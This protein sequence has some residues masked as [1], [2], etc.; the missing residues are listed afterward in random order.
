MKDVFSKKYIKSLPANVFVTKYREDH[1]YLLYKL[2]WKKRGSN[3]S[4]SWVE[5]HRA[6]SILKPEKCSTMLELNQMPN[7]YLEIIPS[8][9][10]GGTTYTIKYGLFFNPYEPDDLKIINKL[11]SKEAFYFFYDKNGEPVGFDKGGMQ[12]SDREFL[13]LD[14]Y[15]EELRDIRLP[16][17]S[18]RRFNSEVVIYY[19]KDWETVPKKY[20]ISPEF[21]IEYVFTQDDL[22]LAADQIWYYLPTRIDYDWDKD[23]TRAAA[24]YFIRSIVH[25]DFSTQGRI[26]IKYQA[27]IL[28]TILDYLGHKLYGKLQKDFYEAVLELITALDSDIELFKTYFS[29]IRIFILRELYEIQKTG[30]KDLSEMSGYVY[31]LIRSTWITVYSI[32][33]TKIQPGHYFYVDDDGYIYSHKFPG[34]LSSSFQKTIYLLESLSDQLL[35]IMGINKCNDLIESSDNYSFS[36][37]YDD[38]PLIENAE[39]ISQDMLKSAMKFREYFITEP[40]EVIIEN[41]IFKSITFYDCDSIYCI[42]KIRTS[43]NKVSY[44]LINKIGFG[45]DWSWWEQF[46]KGQHTIAALCCAIYRDFSVSET[47]LYEKRDIKILK[48]TSKKDKDNKPLNKIVYLP[49][50]KTK[51]IDDTPIIRDV[52][53]KLDRVIERRRHDVSAHLRKVRISASEVQLN[54]ALEYGI[55]V[56]PGYTFVRP[57]HRSGTRKETIYKSRS[58]FGLLIEASR[59]SLSEVQNIIR[60]A[61]EAHDDDMRTAREDLKNWKNILNNFEEFEL[62]VR[63]LVNKMGVE[64]QTTKRS[65]DGGIDIIAEDDRGLARLKYIFQCKFYAPENTVAVGEVR[66]ILGVKAADPTIDKAIFVTSST[67]SPEAHKFAKQNSIT[68]IDGEDLF[69]MVSGIE[70]K[71][72]R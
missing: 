39:E 4:I 67:F 43:D 20:R 50:F 35:W 63:D 14:E 51:Y 29:N 42:C 3:I 59:K 30:D 18:E 33:C 21:K 2:P 22:K 56:P 61:K 27:K 45:V 58:A 1:V 54:L 31:E 62:F 11:L 36:L 52:D 65:Y 26:L 8:F 10:H 71:P 49:R 47:R 19:Y 7:H 34:N 46:P 55:E 69:K 28:Q 53:V 13:D 72:S 24:E 70:T 57:H 16:V 41:K 44:A 64:A 48:K 15:P 9:T 37:I 12:W 68:L 38:L 32:Y 23:L 17:A 5:N 6:N 66:A 60:E 25:K 40:S